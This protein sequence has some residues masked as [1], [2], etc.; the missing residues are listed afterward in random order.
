[1]FNTSAIMNRAWE[2]YRATK[3]TGKRTRKIVAFFFRRALMSA[4]A[5]AK[6]AVANANRTAADL[7][8]ADIAMIENKST[9]TA[10]DWTRR[11][12]LGRQLI[13]AA[14]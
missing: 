11:A 1:M 5:E 3:T 10:A 7:I 2:I 8:R 9:L 4:W 14:S 12:E 6:A 13:G